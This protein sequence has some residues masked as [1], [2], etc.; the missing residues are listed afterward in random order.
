MKTYRLCF[1]RGRE[2][3]GRETFH[4]E[5]AMSA[6]YI[7]AAIFDACSDCC[8]SYELWDGVYRIDVRLPV[9]AAMLDGDRQTRTI[10]T[11]E[12]ILNSAWAVS[13]SQRLLARLRELKNGPEH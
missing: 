12:A 5:D 7:G 3:V 4:A 11:E 1:C 8:D 6:R 9:T 2:L 13:K 10:E